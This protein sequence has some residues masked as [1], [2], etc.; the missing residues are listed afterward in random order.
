MD[1]V[2]NIA[3][4]IGNVKNILV[5]SQSKIRE[6]MQDTIW[7][8]RYVDCMGRDISANKIKRVYEKKKDQA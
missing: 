6:L 8:L 3:A 1:T 4:A 5:M 2:Q 7:C